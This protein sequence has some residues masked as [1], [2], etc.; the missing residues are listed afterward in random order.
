MGGLIDAHSSV[1][2]KLMTVNKRICS[3]EMNTFSYMQSNPKRSFPTCYLDDPN[4][5]TRHQFLSEQLQSGQVL[6]SGIAVLSVS[7]GGR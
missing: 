1:V 3:H 6:P 7:L 4:K 5:P 2:Y